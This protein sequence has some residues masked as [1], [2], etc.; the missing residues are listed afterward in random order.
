MAKIHAR[1]LDNAL[2]ARGCSTVN[3]LINGAPHPAHNPDSN[4]SRIKSDNTVWGTRRTQI[5]NSQHLLL[6]NPRLIEFRPAS[7]LFSCSLISVAT[8]IWSKSLKIAA[9]FPVA[10]T[11]IAIDLKAG[12][13]NLYISLFHAKVKWFNKNCPKQ[14]YEVLVFFKGT[15]VLKVNHNVNISRHVHYFVCSIFR[16]EWQYMDRLDCICL[17][18]TASTVSETRAVPLPTFMLSGDPER[19]WGPWGE[20]GRGQRR[21]PEAA[22]YR[23]TGGWAMCCILFPPHT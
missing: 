22:W 13:I 18:H 10:C 20:R 7:L 5:G 2:N 17:K 3:T 9:D 4:G 21:A 14:F 12:K 16:E 15:L 11:V 23:Q 19:F 1:A 6:L 8:R